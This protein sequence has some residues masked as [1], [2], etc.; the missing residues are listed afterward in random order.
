[1]KQ[2]KLLKRKKAAGM[3]C[4]LPGMLKDCHLHSLVHLASTI[5]LAQAGTQANPFTV[6]FIAWANVVCIL[7]ARAELLIIFDLQT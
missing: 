3:D 2:L 7:I 5:A 6:Q 1:L 4:F